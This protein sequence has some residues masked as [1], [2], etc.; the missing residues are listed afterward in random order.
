MG[1]VDQFERLLDRI[2]PPPDEAVRA[3][4][5]GEA[6]LAHGDVRAAL[7]LAAEAERVAPGWLAPRVLRS[8][9]LTANGQSEEVLWVLDDAAR[10]HDLP[11]EVLG[12]VALLAATVRDVTRALEVERRT[13]GRAVLDPQGLAARFIQTAERL[14][15]MGEADAASRFA[16]AATVLDP[17]RSAAW[18]VL[19]RAAMTVGD[20][21]R[22][23][24]L[25]GRAMVSLE[26]SDAATNRAAGELAWQ[27]DD[28]PLAARCL[29]RAWICG[30]EG[31]APLLVVALTAADDAGAIERVVRGLDRSLAR[32][33]AVLGELARGGPLAAPPVVAAADV[34]DALWPYA[35]ELAVRSDFPLA[36]RWATE[37][38]ARP[39]SAEVLALVT[40][41][42]EVER[43]EV[44]GALELLSL[45]LRSVVTRGRASA[46]LARSFEVAWGSSVDALLAG[47]AGWLRAHAPGQASLATTLDALRRSLDEPLRVAILGEF[48]AGKSTVVNAWVG[49]SL[50]A[51][52]VLPTTARV[53]WLRQGAAR[54]RVLDSR[55]GLREGAIEALPE[56]L[57][58]LEAEGRGVAHVELFHPSGSLAQLELLDTPGSN[59]TDG[60]DPA[61]TRH[62]LA[63]ADLALWIFDARQAGKQSEID[64]L[65]AVRAEGVPVLGAINKADVVG[66]VGAAEVARM[67]HDVLG[68]EA[69]LLGSFGA[70][71]VLTGVKGPDWEAFR[72]SVA[73]RVVGRRDAWKRLRAAVRLR[74][75]LS[76][77]QREMGE[78][79]AREAT[80][81]GVEAQLVD[82]LD[83]LRQGVSERSTQVRREVAASLREQWP[84]LRGKNAAPSEDVL[85]DVVAELVHRCIQHERAI[86]AEQ[87]EAVEA[88]AVTAGAVRPGLGAVFTAPVDGMIRAAVSEGVR[89]ASDQAFRP[90]AL[91]QVTSGPAQ[92]L[93]IGDPWREVSAALDATRAPADLPSVMLAVALRA[94]VECAQRS[95]DALAGTLGVKVPDAT[96]EPKD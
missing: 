34:P 69:P 16:R 88:L 57:R 81:R 14:E 79:D 94:A 67:L 56:T 87:R 19:A 65:R 47:L 52:G 2:M 75:I 91:G 61:V 95:A 30:A 89:D 13:R 82:A 45:P 32:V 62:A 5:R 33:V 46:L 22:A 54:A 3:L 55:G 44:D 43:G 37:C 80:R 26:P 77:V 63:L 64:A 17:A 68:D 20:P 84:S 25:L 7:V 51:V 71:P 53:Y 48:S 66:A 58:A 60:V 27:L 38:P 23:H 42:I 49:A 28:R 73:Q 10:E 85:R 74:A 72:A 41:S 92:G 12:R 78:A 70:R 86:L 90:S 39:A 24:R 29:R 93:D 11:A 50:S 1:L 15:V 8:D 83:A 6:L 4:R 96:S 36:V 35:I 76:E 31:A 21:A 18:L 9:A 40:A 59:A